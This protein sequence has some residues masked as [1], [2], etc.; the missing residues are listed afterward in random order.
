MDKAQR[1]A[2]AQYLL[3]HPLVIEALD[4]IERHAVQEFKRAPWFQHRK[5]RDAQIMLQ[6]VDK[7]RGHLR[8]QLD[9]RKGA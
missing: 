2:E 4:A 5:R 8:S 6:H 1:H 3:S 9:P 7:F